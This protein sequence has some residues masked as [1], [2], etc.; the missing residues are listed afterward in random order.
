MGEEGDGCGK[1]LLSDDFVDSCAVS[2][3]RAAGSAHM[4]PSLYSL[5][6]GSGREDRQ[7]QTAA[8]QRSEFHGQVVDWVSVHH[9][10]AL[11]HA[12]AAR[13][14]STRVTACMLF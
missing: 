9:L 11:E 8:G 6:Q 12:H 1:L 2:N 14:L 10:R 3:T 4:S 5:F 13:M 7:R